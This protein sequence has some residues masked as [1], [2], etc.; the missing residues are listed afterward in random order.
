MSDKMEQQM[1]TQN[2]LLAAIATELAAMVGDESGGATYETNDDGTAAFRTTN[3][4][5]YEHKRNPNYV[6]REL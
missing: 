2:K 5:R 1:A 3:L 6:E 4:T